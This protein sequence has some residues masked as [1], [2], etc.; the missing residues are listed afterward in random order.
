MPLWLYGQYSINYC[1]KTIDHSQYP[2][3]HVRLVIFWDS[4]IRTVPSSGT[5]PSIKI[6][7]VHASNMNGVHTANSAGHWETLILTSR[8]LGLWIISLDQVCLVYSSSASQ[9][10]INRLFLAS[11]SDLYL[12]HSISFSCFKDLCDVFFALRTRALYF[13][14]PFV[15]TCEAILMLA[16]V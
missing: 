9:A 6:S 2:C 1:Q 5:C 12:D 3:M 16:A 4:A 15:D 10:D 8:K 7:P 13:H 11:M 14:D